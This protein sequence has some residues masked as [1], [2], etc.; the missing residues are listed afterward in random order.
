MKTI[1]ADNYTFADCRRDD[2]CQPA[3]YAG[4]R[5]DQQ[6]FHSNSRRTHRG[7][8]PASKGQRL[9]VGRRS[10]SVSCKYILRRSLRP[11]EVQT[12]Y[13]GRMFRYNLTHDTSLVSKFIISIAAKYTKILRIMQNQLKRSHVFDLYNNYNLLPL[14]S[15]HNHQLLIFVFK[16]VYYSQ[17]V[18]SAF[19]DYFIF[20]R[21]IHT[22]NTRMHNDLHIFAYISTTKWYEIQDYR[23]Q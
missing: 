1:W 15:L 6:R 22:Y 7:L 2:W 10:C 16:R 21:Q 20:N 3:D 23:K 4:N 12:K 8:D 5:Q 18:P 17:L 14:V 9:K 13:R 19:H 11:Y